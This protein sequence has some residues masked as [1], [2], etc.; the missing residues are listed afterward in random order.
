MATSCKMDLIT[1]NGTC[2]ENG[3]AASNLR[4]PTLADPGERLQKGRVNPPVGR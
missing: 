4:S 1:P 3:A 2:D